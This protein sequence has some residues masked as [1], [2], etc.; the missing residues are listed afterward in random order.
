M[1]I[2]ITLPAQLIAK[3]AD[4]H[5]TIEIRSKIPKHFNCNQDYCYV[6]QQGSKSITLRFKISQFKWGDD[7]PSIWTYWQH[8]FAVPEDWFLRYT[9]NKSICWFWFIDKQSVEIIDNGVDLYNSLH[10]KT[11]PQSYRYLDGIE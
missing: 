4:G 6:A 5:K 3:I 9:K 7:Y 8:D 1:N 10:L 11:N 2:L